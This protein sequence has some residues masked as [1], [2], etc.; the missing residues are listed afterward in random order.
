MR[1]F[2]IV[3]VILLFCS[4][5]VA[6]AQERF[7]Q[8][9][10]RSGFNSIRTENGI[11][12]KWRVEDQNLRVVISARTK[13]WVAVGF[14]PSEKMKDANFI[15][16]YVKKGTVYINDEYGI[17]KGGHVADTKIDGSS[18]ILE[19]NGS[20]KNDITEIEFVIP[21]DSGDTKDRPLEP[22]EDYLILLAYGK[23]DSFQSPHS[24]EAE[25]KGFIKL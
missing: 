7:T 17:K 20:E 9:V 11:V 24:I 25:A 10:D 22:G 15:I 4:F 14:N 21:L 5:A 3:I 23:G 1:R 12:F 13:G 8:E 19:R 2:L 6:E 18:D 16:G